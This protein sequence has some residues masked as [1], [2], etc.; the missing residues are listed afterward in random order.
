MKTKISISSFSSKIMTAVLFA[1]CLFSTTASAISPEM[2][3]ETKTFQNPDFPFDRE[4]FICTPLEYDYNPQSEVDVV[5]VFDSQW[6]SHFA[7]AYSILGEC[8]NPYEDNIPFIVVGI[9][10]P[11]T[12]EYCRT[13]DFLPVPTNV[14]YETPY[15]GNYENFKKFIREDVMP[16]VNNNYR[17]SGHTLAIGHSLGA[18]FILNALSS[19]EMFD[20]YIALSPN[21]MEDD[22]KFANDFLNY[23]FEN[24]E[25]RFLFLTMSNESEETG[26]GANWRPA[27]DMVKSKM[28]SATFPE[29]IKLFFKE[30]PEHTHMSGYAQCL[31]DILPL[32]A[33]YRHT[34]YITDQTKHSVHIEL[35]CPAADGDV[36]ITGNQEVAANWNPQGV[37]MNKVDD[38]TYAIDLNVQLPFEFKFT[39]GAWENQINTANA[40][41][42]NLR[43]FSPDKNF[44]HYIAQ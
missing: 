2:R 4:I 42:G 31:M 18:S 9:P 19:E 32:Y 44:K 6:R 11:N 21:F 29:K 30:Y 12:S 13:N 35:E 28:E 36:F 10:S 16:Y 17:T 37:K 14:K 20:D 8:Q 1:V 24:S 3:V 27:W 23:D 25:P 22:F 34:T 40:Y 7:L 33:M 39:Q 38:K 26:M 41:A 5:Y 15:Y 43:I